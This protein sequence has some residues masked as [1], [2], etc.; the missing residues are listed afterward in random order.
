MDCNSNDV[1][2]YL[3][4]LREIKKSLGSYKVSYDEGLYTLYDGDDIPKLTITEKIYRV[5]REIEI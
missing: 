3:G 2:N 5:F 4:R 1:L